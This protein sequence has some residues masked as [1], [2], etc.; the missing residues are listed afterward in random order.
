MIETIRIHQNAQNFT[1]KRKTIR[2]G[3]H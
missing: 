3:H 2:H 1:F